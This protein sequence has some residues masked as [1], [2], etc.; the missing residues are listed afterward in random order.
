MPP[1]QIAVQELLDQ[2]FHLGA[3]GQ[4]YRDHN[5]GNRDVGDNHT[6]LIGDTITPGYHPVTNRNPAQVLTVSKIELKIRLEGRPVTRVW[7]IRAVAGD[8]L[9]PHHGPGVNREEATIA[10]RLYDALPSVLVAE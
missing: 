8:F 3:G 1:G 5:Y 4:W 2:N 6:H 10:R 7:L 9:L